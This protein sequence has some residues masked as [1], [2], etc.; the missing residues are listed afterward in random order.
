MK[1]LV[2][3][4]VGGSRPDAAT[5]VVDLPEDYDFSQDIHEPSHTAHFKNLKR[6][7]QEQMPSGFHDAAWMLRDLTVDRAQVIAVSKLG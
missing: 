7:C 4:F 3:L 1:Y 5:I 6:I 2:T